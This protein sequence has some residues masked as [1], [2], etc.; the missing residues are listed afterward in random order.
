MYKITYTLN[1]G[2]LRF[3]SVETLF[4]ATLFSNKLPVGSVL[5]IKY[6]DNDTTKKPG[7]N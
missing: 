3:K 2:S 6:Y 4:E 1:S 5:E 7:R